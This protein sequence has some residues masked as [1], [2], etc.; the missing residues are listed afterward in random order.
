MKKFRLWCVNKKEWEK[1]EWVLS[2]SGNIIE[3]RSSRLLNP[4]NHILEQW[5]GLTDKNGVK[6]F[7]GDIV[8]LR[9]RAKG[10]QQGVVIFSEKAAK[11]AVRIHRQ[12]YRKNEPHL[13]SLLNSEI[14]GN[15]HETEDK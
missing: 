4:K 9:G 15:I 2:S 8:K 10:P 5:T 12:G 13:V 11:F 6:I 7:E 14:I 1:D 3:V